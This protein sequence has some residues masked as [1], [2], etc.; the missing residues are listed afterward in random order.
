MDD[1]IVRH[2]AN[3]D[4]VV[5]PPDHEDQVKAMAVRLRAILLQPNSTRREKMWE[6]HDDESLNPAYKWDLIAE[7]F[8]LVMAYELDRGI[9]L[10]VT[11][12]G[13]HLAGFVSFA[14]RH[15]KP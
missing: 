6:L 10:E 11:L 1:M 7:A 14:R 2:S 15:L 8:P 4:L 13:R 9:D 3:G 5:L 12:L